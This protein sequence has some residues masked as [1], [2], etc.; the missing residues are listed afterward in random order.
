MINDQE[1]D[2]A[3]Q[4]V[5]LRCDQI[6]AMSEVAGQ[7]TRTFCCPSM[8]N[9]HDSIAA[10]MR[11]INLSCHADAAGNLIGQPGGSEQPVMMI[12]SHLDTVVNAGRYDGVLGVLLG[13]AAA[14]LIHQ[15]KQEL[16]FDL[17]IVGFSDEEGVRFNRPYIGSS[18][19]AGCFDPKVLDVKDADGFTVK[20]ALSGFGCE[21][22][23]WSSASFVNRNVIGFIEAHI[24]QGPVLQSESQSVGVVSAIA[25]QTRATIRVAGTAGHA[26]TVPHQ[27][28]RDALA[29]AAE[30]V[31]SIEQLGQSTEG[32]VA[33]VGQLDVSPNASNVIPGEV[34]L[35]LDLRHVDDSVRKICLEKICDA[36]SEV[37]TRRSLQINIDVNLDQPAV[38]MDSK[39]TQA[40]SDAIRDTGCIPIEMLSGAGHD[41]AVMVNLAP[42]AMLFVR[43][44]DGVSHHP[45]EHVELDD[46]SVALKVLLAG[47]RR[48]SNSQ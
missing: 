8:R 28:R 15:S 13:L 4:R 27:L 25:G 38:P 6:A 37:A 12:G 21:P 36:M 2:A 44:R 30:L 35:T 39:I 29:A 1:F 19:V 24:E 20:S 22:D 18:A 42:S 32:L 5:L 26:G 34:Q 47:L 23:Q 3:V 14:E 41:A 11:A 7:T 33:T 40:L 10:W 46:V 16:G 17:V 45:D 31:L 48:I 9:V 43:C